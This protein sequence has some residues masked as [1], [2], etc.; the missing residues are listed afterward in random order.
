MGRT[1]SPQDLFPGRKPPSP[2]GTSFE[3]PGPSSS[4]RVA[5]QLQIEDSVMPDAKGVEG[6]QPRPSLLRA[7]TRRPLRK[8]G[9]SGPPPGPMSPAGPP[10]AHTP[11]PAPAQPT[12]RADRPRPTGAGCRLDDLYRM[13][14][15]NLF[16]LAEKEG[17]NEHTGM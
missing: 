12:D 3:P 17:I 1:V 2:T 8:P 7:A 6:S 13:P 10:G 9:E 14:M 5:F 16:K 11:A 15:P 4:G